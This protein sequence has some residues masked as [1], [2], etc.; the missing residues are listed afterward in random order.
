MTK[1]FT[2]TLKP[3]SKNYVIDAFIGYH[4]IN[5]HTSL[6]Y[7][8]S[9]LPLSF[10][11]NASYHFHTQLIGSR[12]LRTTSYIV[13]LGSVSAAILLGNIER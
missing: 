12:Y 5:S 3:G 1:K 10:G 11:K 7:F 8:S 2:T 13:T 9:S 4:P 6:E